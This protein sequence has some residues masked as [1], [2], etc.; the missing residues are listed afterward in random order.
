MSNEKVTKQQHP[1]TNVTRNWQ[2]WGVCNIP[3][4]IVSFLLILV[5]L[6]T[7]CY[8]FVTRKERDGK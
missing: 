3:F 4:Y 6:V 1:V 7:P 2:F 8:G 5:T